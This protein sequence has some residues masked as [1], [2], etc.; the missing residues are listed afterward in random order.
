MV[1]AMMM[2]GNHAAPAYRTAAGTT[3]NAAA[4]TSAGNHASEPRSVAA[5]TMIFV[6]TEVGKVFTHSPDS[7]DN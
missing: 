4:T 3:P 7:S 1:T 5:I 6:S 2:L